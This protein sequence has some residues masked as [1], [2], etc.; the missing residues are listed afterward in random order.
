MIELL[1]ECVSRKK[2]KNNLCPYVLN[3]LKKKGGGERRI[4]LLSSLA[5]QYLNGNDLKHQTPSFS[6]VEVRVVVEKFK[7][8]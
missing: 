3:L 2:Y 4:V 6:G 7:R 1:N 8:R 5:R